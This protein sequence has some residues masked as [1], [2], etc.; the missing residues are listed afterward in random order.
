MAWNLTNFVPQAAAFAFS[1]VFILL[2]W[3][4]FK[5]ALYNC[6]GSNKCFCN[7][8]LWGFA[9]TRPVLQDLERIYESLCEMSAFYFIVFLTVAGPGEDL[10]ESLRDVRLL[11][12]SVSPVLQDL[13]RI[14]ESLCEMS[15]FCR[16]R[17][18][19]LR[20]LA[21]TVRYQAALANDILFW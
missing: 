1:S 21:L 5:V 15:A 16:L 8:I 17:D 7:L 9:C 14:Y 18:S 13:E 11:S 3:Q 12:H 6:I 10:R 2:L 20:S 4:K 19:E